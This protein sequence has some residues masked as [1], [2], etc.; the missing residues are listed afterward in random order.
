MEDQFS[1]PTTRTILMFTIHEDVGDRVAVIPGFVMVWEFGSDPEIG[2]G[3]QFFSTGE[4]NVRS[5]E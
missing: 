4:Q 1:H 5:R 3:V 2:F